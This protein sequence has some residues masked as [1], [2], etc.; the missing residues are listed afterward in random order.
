LIDLI[1]YNVTSE[2][3]KRERE[4]M[5]NF[6]VTHLIKPVLFERLYF[7]CMTFG[8]NSRKTITYFLSLAARMD[9]TERVGS[10]MARISLRILTFGW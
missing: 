4:K 1:D 6:S 5:L 9:T 10:S 7:K 8:K 3:D 2:R